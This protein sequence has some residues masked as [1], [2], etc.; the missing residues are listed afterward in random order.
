MTAVDQNEFLGFATAAALR[1]VQTP[2]KIGHLRLTQKFTLRKGVELPK[3]RE[4]EMRHAFAQ[5][6]EERGI[7]YGIEVPT[8]N[9]YRF[10]LVEGPRHVAA[11][12]DVALYSLPDVTKP[13]TVLIELKEGQPQPTTSPSGGDIEDVR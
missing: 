1:T 6:A 3:I 7:D 9:K 2:G 12:H 4:P 11:R 10:R 13:P 5:A 8:I